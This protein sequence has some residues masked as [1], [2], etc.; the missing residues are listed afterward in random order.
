MMNIELYKS[1]KMLFIGGN[2]MPRCPKCNS[3]NVENLSNE[4]LDPIPTIRDFFPFLEKK[5]FICKNCGHE[6]EA[7]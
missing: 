1:F 6:F 4:M 3:A 7:K 2:I 5:R